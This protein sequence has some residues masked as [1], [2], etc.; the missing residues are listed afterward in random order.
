[1][2]AITTVRGGVSSELAEWLER[3]LSGGVTRLALRHKSE[4][5]G[6]TL[7]REFSMNDG[8]SIPGLA[9]MVSRRAHDDGRHFRGRSLYG[10]F[11]FNDHE[12]VDRFFIAVEGAE[13]MAY[14]GSREANLSG[15]TQQLMRHNEAN[16]RLAIGQT[17]DVINH[18]RSLLQQ[19]EKRIEELEAK[20]WKVGELYEHLTSMQH[21]RQL[22]VMRMQQADKR[23]EFLKEKLDM[24]A[25]VLMSKVMPGA[26]KGAALG[27]ELVR[28]FL[29]SLTP[30]QMG[31]ILGALSPEQAAVINEVYVAYAEREVAKDEPKKTKRSP[32]AGGTT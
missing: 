5:G 16:A 9:D 20:Y 6:E 17:L 1:M 31:A 13:D 2:S 24:L 14:F 21:E 15:V 29:K 19:R 4:D 25:P 28:Q 12:Y 22:D 32:P 27:E 7:V 3:Q 26:S 11:A 23:Q 18:Y 30:E 10:V 8:G